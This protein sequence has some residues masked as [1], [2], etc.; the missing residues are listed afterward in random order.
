MP[1]TESLHSHPSCG[2]PTPSRSNIRL[3]F[4]LPYE[5]PVGASLF[6]EIS[7]LPVDE[8]FARDARICAVGLFVAVRVATTIAPMRTQDTHT[9]L[10]SPPLQTANRTCFRGFE[11]HV[12][13]LVK[14]QRSSMVGRYV[15]L[16]RAAEQ[17]HGPHE[18]PL[19][20]EI[21]DETPFHGELRRDAHEHGP[22]HTQH[23]RS[24]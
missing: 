16:G 4:R 7:C 21:F 9:S 5:L 15:R 14:S 18:R 2:R 24:V 8:L 19:Q 12:Y 20:R 10:P 1:D 17:L 11:L 22:G 13:D 3:G 6:E 23:L